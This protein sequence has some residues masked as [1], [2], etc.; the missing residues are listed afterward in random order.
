MKDFKGASRW[1]PAHPEKRNSMSANLSRGDCLNHVADGVAGGLT[2]FDIDCQYNVIQ[3]P[4]KDIMKSLVLPNSL[5]LNMKD[6]STP[7]L[8]GLQQ[9]IDNWTFTYL[10]R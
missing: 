3:L 4:A 2:D 5:A 7:I 6:G 10:Q 1:T 8:A 9:Q